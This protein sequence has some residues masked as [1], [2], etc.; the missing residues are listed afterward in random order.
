[1]GSDREDNSET[2][3]GKDKMLVRFVTW[4]VLIAAGAAALVEAWGSCQDCKD[5]MTT[6]FNTLQSPNVVKKEAV[7]FEKK[8][9]VGEEDDEKC[10]LFVSHWGEMQ[11]AWLTDKST[12]EDFCKNANMCDSH[13]KRKYLSEDEACSRCKQ[14]V[15]SFAA[16][17]GQPTVS[18]KTVDLL[19]GQAYCGQ[20]NLAF[21]PELVETFVPKALSFLKEELPKNQ[22]AVCIAAK[23]CQG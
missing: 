14:G 18:K 5:G 17:L 12:A 4:F 6:I 19:K 3:R 22:V 2:R 8:F 9:C 13:P 16:Y 7:E 11:T 23:A 1:M 15:K 21:C 20:V 10:K